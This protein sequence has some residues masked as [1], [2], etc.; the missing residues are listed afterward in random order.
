MEEFFGSLRDLNGISYSLSAKFS[1]IE[2]LNQAEKIHHITSEFEKDDLGLRINLVIT[3][4]DER[5]YDVG[6]K[7][8]LRGKERFREGQS[9]K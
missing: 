4:F 5:D 7:L 2:P 8:Y 9:K 6:G 1:D 3:F